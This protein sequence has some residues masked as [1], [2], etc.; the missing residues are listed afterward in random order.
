MESSN[1]CPCC[2]SQMFERPDEEIED[3][4]DEESDEESED[5][6]EF[7]TIEEICAD[8]QSQGATYLDLCSLLVNRYSKVDPRYTDDAIDMMERRVDE[9]LD[10]LDQVAFDRNTE[11]L[12][13]E[14][15]ES[16]EDVEE[17]A[18]WVAEKEEKEVVVPTYTKPLSKLWDEDYSDWETDN[19]DDEEEEE[20]NEEIMVFTRKELECDAEYKRLYSAVPE[21]LWFE[22]EEALSFGRYNDET[23]AYCENADDDET[24][25]YNIQAE[26]SENQKKYPLVCGVCI[27]PTCN[28]ECHK[29]YVEF[30][31]QSYDQ[32]P[33]RCVYCDKFGCKEHVQMHVKLCKQI[34]E[35]VR[36][37]DCENFDCSN[38]EHWSV[39]THGFELQEDQLQWLADGQK[40]WEH[41]EHG[42]D[43]AD[44]IVCSII[45]SEAHVDIKFTGASCQEEDDDEES[46]WE[47]ID[48]EETTDDEESVWEDIED[49]EEPAEVS[50]WT[51]EQSRVIHV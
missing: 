20:N 3:S 44:C 36:C 35:H 2:R 49:D 30:F 40:E 11:R 33:K 7:A 9:T 51:W 16:G 47:D 14:E 41:H 19:D 21:E 42:C 25:H 8:F 34:D 22:S 37:A 10:R 27:D 43:N 31:Q 1:L 12:A 29:E 17:P 45:N 15:A 24:H 38:R 18:D 26:L 4:D 28:A 32:V 6:N 50:E 48:D 5:E 13:A 23:S 46:I 39:N